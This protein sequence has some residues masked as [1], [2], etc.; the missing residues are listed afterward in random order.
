MHT[1]D[2]DT[3]NATPAEGEYKRED[4]AVEIEEADGSEEDLLYSLAD[5]NIDDL[6]KHMGNVRCSTLDPDFD[7]I[8]NLDLNIE[9]VHIEFM[10]QYEGELPEAV[11]YMAMRVR[12]EQFNRGGNT[13][14]GIFLDLIPY[15]WPEHFRHMFPSPIQI[16]L[17]TVEDR[18][19]TPSVLQAIGQLN[20]ALE[21]SIIVFEKL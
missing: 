5:D 15:Q 1:P 20:R 9:Q 12:P 7:G 21:N 8:E 3:Q 14:L 18:K 17:G 13:E 10:E 2:T 4:F 19:L 11:P 16:V 6:M